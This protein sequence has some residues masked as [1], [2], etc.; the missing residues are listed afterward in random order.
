MAVIDPTK[1]NSDFTKFHNLN[2]KMRRDI[3]LTDLDAIQFRIQDDGSER[4]R[5]IEYKHNNEP[6]RKMQN[7]ILKRFMAFIPDVNRLSENIQ[8]ELYMIICDFEKN[9]LIGVAT[10][11]NLIKKRSKI[12]N[13]DQLISLLNFDINWEDL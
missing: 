7:E 4:I 8:F 11:Y 13:E 1:Y 3:S 2:P 5:F 6:Q 12:I 9:H 10:V